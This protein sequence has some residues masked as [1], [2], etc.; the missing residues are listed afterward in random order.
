MTGASEIVPLSDGTQVGI[1][2]V[3]PPHAAE[4]IDHIRVEAADD[5]GDV[6]AHAS[7]D[8]LYGPRGEVTVEID[9]RHRQLGL[10]S[11]LLRRLA[12]EAERAGI[13]H[14]ITELRSEDLA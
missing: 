1:R 10:A 7:C 9:E 3:R 5:R 2:S 6:I 12:Q 11:V 4:A 14:L 8:R 13:K